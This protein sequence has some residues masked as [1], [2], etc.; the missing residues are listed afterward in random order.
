[1]SSSGNMSHTQPNPATRNPSD[2]AKREGYE[3]GVSENVAFGDHTA[4]A[5]HKGWY[6]SSG[7]LPI[8]STVIFVEN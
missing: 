8:L 2:R 7:G 6:T 1:M 3:S 5:V 4:A